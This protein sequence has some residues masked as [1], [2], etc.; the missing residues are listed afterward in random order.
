MAKQPQKQPGTGLPPL[1]PLEYCRLGRAASLLGCEEGDLIHWGSINAI[2]LYVLFSSHSSALGSGICLIHDNQ[3]M[4]RRDDMSGYGR[5]M[6]IALN[7]RAG[8]RL[9]S[10]VEYST[11]DCVGW[12]N[13][14]W[15][16]WP[17]RLKIMELTPDAQE[18][19]YVAARDCKNEVV[20]AGVGHKYATR[21]VYFN[22]VTSALGLEEAEKNPP[23]VELAAHDLWIFR[24]DLELVHQHIHSGKPLPIDTDNAEQAATAEM[25]ADSEKPVP[26]TTLNQSKAITELLTKLGYTDDDFRG[27]I[28]ALQQKLSRDGLG[29]TLTD[30][31]KNTLT[32][33]LERAGV[34]W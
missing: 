30:I 9:I 32:A 8:Y 14:F 13:G 31:D 23:M 2:S 21:G 12:L 33:W 10:A 16:V 34:R 25:A 29:G 5:S 22:A 11:R 6:D 1:L 7:D 3:W 20:V 24:K 18:P 4:N 17:P 26:R 28:G 15:R 27:S 19:F